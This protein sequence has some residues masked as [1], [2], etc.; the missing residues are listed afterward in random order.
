M[1]KSFIVTGHHAVEKKERAH[2][3][4]R[5]MTPT[6]TLLWQHLR[7]NQL[8]G[9]HFRRQQVIDGFIADFYCHKAGLVIEVDGAVHEHR[10]DY[11]T[12]RDQI[13]SARG[14]TIVR[15]PNERIHNDIAAVLTE[16]GTAAQS[17]LQAHSTEPA[18]DK[19]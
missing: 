17:L 7:R 16:I 12:E 5:E 8:A 4:R 15:I 14:L 1:D 11:D 2:Q 13:I 19:P 10:V 18:L 9:L 6:E 3:F